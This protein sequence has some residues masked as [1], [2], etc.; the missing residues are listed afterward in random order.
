MATFLLEDM[1][2]RVDMVAFPESYKRYYELIQEDLLVW[3][4][5]QVQ[6]N[7]DSV[8]IQVQQMMTLEEALESNAKRMI[9]RVQLPAMEA[10][11]L[12]ALKALLKDSEGECPVFFE[13]STAEGNLILVQSVDLPGVKPTENLSRQLTELLGENAVIVQY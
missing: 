3:I 10:A 2:G 7:S 5:G 6:G 8:K 12:S 13:L 9:L 1:T 11:T 4:K